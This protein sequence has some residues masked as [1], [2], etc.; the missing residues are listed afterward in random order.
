MRYARSCLQ[1]SSWTAGRSR[2]LYPQPEAAAPQVTPEQEQEMWR[3]YSLNAGPEARSPVVEAARQQ[4]TGQG[5]LAFTREQFGQFVQQQQA[6][7]QPSREAVN[8]DPAQPQGTEPL[9]NE[10]QPGEPTQQNPSQ[11]WSPTTDNSPEADVDISQT[12]NA[13][14]SPVTGNLP[15]D[16]RAARQ[17]L[18]RA[19]RGSMSTFERWFLSPILTISKQNPVTRPAARVM[20]YF[21]RRT[22]EF[23][24][25][26]QAGLAQN[27]SNLSRDDMIALTDAREQSS[28]LRAEAPSVAQ[29][30]P[31]ARAAFDSQIAATRRASEYLGE[32]ASIKYF[33]PASVKDPATKARLNEMWQRHRNKHLWEIPAQE[34]QAASPEGYQN[35]QNSC[36]P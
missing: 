22:N 1:P 36:Q 31:A 17:V 5:R 20:S 19:A 25:E 3:G 10:S 11:E 2:K 32:A 23:N 6:A 29:L 34:L 8:A 35:Y 12:G 28:L 33:D 7:P 24:A 18:Q 13:I 27:M 15:P 9:P 4:T 30:S 16:S 21:R 14:W 26:V